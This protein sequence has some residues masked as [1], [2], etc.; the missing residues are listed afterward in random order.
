[1]TYRSN[2]VVGETALSGNKIEKSPES[3]A[4]ACQNKLHCRWKS[5]EDKVVTANENSCITCSFPLSLSPHI[6]K[7][8]LDGST[9]PPN[10]PI[11]IL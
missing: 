10:Q 3:H 2:A 11:E 9:F 4:A 8:P 5:D 1:M 7:S 6:A